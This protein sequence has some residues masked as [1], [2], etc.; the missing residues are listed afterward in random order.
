[1]AISKFR[2]SPG[3]SRVSKSLSPT[4]AGYVQAIRS[5]MRAIEKDFEAFVGHM[6]SVSPEILEEALRPTFDES[7][8]LVPKDT[9]A[10]E[11]SGYLESR[12]SAKGSQVEI[13]YGKNGQ[14][15]YSIIVHER[16]ELNHE[17]PT[18]AKFLQEPIERN[19]FN[20]QRRLVDL[21]KQ[22]SGT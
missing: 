4:S 2:I 16:L 17:F 8:E 7:Q 22:A 14:P 10:L 21:Y 9:G 18:Q 11:E 3:R 20:I 12:R 1:M 6:V 19:F 15:P 5:Q 13:G